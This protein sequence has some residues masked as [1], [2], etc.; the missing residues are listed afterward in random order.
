MA[1]DRLDDVHL[2]SQTAAGDREAFALFFDRH[3]PR[4][5]GLLIKLLRSRSDADDVLQDTFCS[6]WS[7][8]G[9]Y[10][11]QRGSPIAWV[12]LIARS[13]AIDHL[14]RRRR[15]GSS[16]AAPV[17]RVAEDCGARRV[18][19]HESHSNA[20]RALTLLPE[21]QRSLIELAFYGGLTHEQIAATRSIPLGTVKTRI[22]LGM[23]RLREALAGEVMQ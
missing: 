4:A 3:A 14:R 1:G 9:E 10:N 21:E 5:L 16:E 2:L 15:D 7:K 17:E 11:A 20:R 8:A 22:R 12:L 6:V 13:R 18:E 23:K 19:E